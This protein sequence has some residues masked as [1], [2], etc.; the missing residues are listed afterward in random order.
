MGRPA[1]KANVDDLAH[2]I[3]LRNVY[4]SRILLRRLIDNHATTDFE[5]PAMEEPEDTPPEPPARNLEPDWWHTMW[6][7]DLITARGPL[8]GEAPTIAHIQTV[9]A[10]SYK[11][12]RADLTSARRTHNVVLPRQIAMYFA[13]TMT[14]RSYPEIGRRFGGR[15]HTTAIHSVQKIT[16]RCV[17][18]PE[19]ARTIAALKADILA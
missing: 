14:P 9:V 19:F 18:D 13:K 6:F 1:D 15:D 10:R 3:H 7:G 12:T 2:F 4:C 8:K 16:A 11:L 17:S 5:M